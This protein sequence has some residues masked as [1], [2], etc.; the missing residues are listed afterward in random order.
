[1]ARCHRIGQ[2]KPVTVYRLVTQDSVEE[3]A[4]S[5]LAKKLYLSIKVTT[6][7]I[8]GSAT[9]EH[10][11]SLTAGELV[12]MLR[13]GTTAL[14]APIGEHWNSKSIDEILSESR[15]RQRKR[16][17]MFEMSDGQVELMEAD[18][19]K[20]QERI[21]TNIFEGQVLSRSNEEIADG[22]AFP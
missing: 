20:D 17:E 15:E 8:H 11:P 6:A 4:L 18:L 1:M 19:L 10:G 12:K 5:R 9:N 22:I 14:S 13:A 21:K 2:T 3:Q 16:E 7:A